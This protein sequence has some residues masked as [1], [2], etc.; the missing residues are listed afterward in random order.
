MRH[1]MGVI[2]KLAMVMVL[3]SVAA[4][5]AHAQG[6]QNIDGKKAEEVY[7]N[8]VALKGMQASEFNQTMH[9]MEAETGM[10]CT[11]C[12]VEGAF[13]KE[14]KAP[15]QIARQMIMMM[16]N[17]NQQNFSGKRVV[18]CYTC[19]NGRPIPM[20]QPTVLPVA[21]PALADPMIPAPKVAIPSV[22]QI[23]AKYVDA[24]G[25]EQAL[26]KVTSRVITGTQMIPTGPG[27]AVPVP[28]TI[29]RLQKAPNLVV[30]TYRTP[31]NTIA[32]GFDGTKAWTMSAQGRVTEP[33]NI[34]QGRAKRDA[35]FFL[36]LNL[37]QVYP[38]LEVTGVE[39]VNGRDAYLVVGT[40]QG[41]LPERLY[42]DIQNGLLIRKE[43][44]LPTP[45]GNS[46]FQVNFSDYRDTGSGVKF[47]FQI[48]MNPATS[49]SV[50]FS[51]AT[52]RVNTVQDNAPI[53]AAKLARPES[54]PAPPPAAAPAR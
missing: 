5:L 35:D 43:A 13:D 34:D 23:L 18:T 9:L 7:K 38:K 28:A 47:P 29:E 46:T 14:D 40:P 22:D 1:L 21:K 48:T 6:G 2:G 32:D 11:F 41:D 16:N 49:R 52:I 53:D 51:T 30:N 15:K 26:R 8:I 3:A 17:L 44:D 36:P 33:L 27:G 54:R 12:H 24:L 50:L 4:S 37:K 20:S 31:T 10:D 42:F 19:H 25:G 39:R 45:V